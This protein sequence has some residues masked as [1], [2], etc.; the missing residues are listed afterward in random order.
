M[1]LRRAGSPGCSRGDE[2]PA[3]T[4]HVVDAAEPRS[5]PQYRVLDNCVATMLDRMA[6]ISVVIPTYQRESDLVRTIQ[7]VLAQPGD[8]E[9]VVV[10]QT[11]SHSGPTE[12]F[13]R[14]VDD[15]RFS[16]HLVGPPSLTAAR[17]YGI[18]N[19]TG[20]IVIFVD[21]DVELRPGFLAAH[22]QQYDDASVGAVGGRV[23]GPTE[24][25]DPSPAYLA[26]TGFRRGSFDCPRDAEATLVRG[27][28]MSF[29]R[30]A[31]EEA[32]GFDGRFIGNAIREDFDAALSVS[33]AGWKVLYTPTAA[34][35]H[36]D[37]ATG[38]CHG[39]V[40]YAHD[41]TYFR[42]V[43]LFFV[44][45]RRYRQ[46]LAY[47]VINMMSAMRR[48]DPSHLGALLAGLGRGIKARSVARPVV[49]DEIGRQWT[50]QPES[51]E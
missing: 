35:D 27:C 12:A 21:D 8:F 43:T 15:P 23:I 41:A 31:I 18:E 38:G 4:G 51:A 26:W 13:L 42:N 20:D 17:N 19:S 36:H 47:T 33:A 22:A 46:L 44:K 5:H 7:S 48:L 16:Y 45:H 6:S 2:V 49:S 39:D 50:P 10:D 24:S 29:R 34:L 11:P 30:R 37:V 9:I 32:G 14:G 3:T 28:N 40:P 25:P 1:T